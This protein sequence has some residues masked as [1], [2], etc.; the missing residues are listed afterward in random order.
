[1]CLANSKLTIF[2]HDKIK[3]KI[4]NEKL[5]IVF[6]GLPIESVQ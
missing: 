6:H 3:S 5:G 2:V 4:L 1:M